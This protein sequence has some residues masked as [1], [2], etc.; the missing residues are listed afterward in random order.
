[1]IEHEN[2]KAGIKTIFLKKVMT[3]TNSR[4]TV[5]IMASPFSWGGGSELIRLIV[6]SLS[7]E[8]NDSTKIIVFFGRNKFD[9][10]LNTLNFIKNIFHKGKKISSSLTESEMIDF[11]KDIPGIH[12][13]HYTNSPNYK[14]LLNKLQLNKVDALIPVPTVL[15]DSFS[16]PWI[17]YIPDLQHKHL[18]HFFT[19]EEITTRDNLYSQMLLKAKTVIVNSIQVK[20]DLYKYY[21]VKSKIFSL[22]FAP[23]CEAKWL[24]NKNDSQIIKKYSLPNKFFMI[25]NQFWVHKSYET[26]FESMTNSNFQKQNIHLVCTGNLSDYRFP[27]YILKLK[28]QISENNLTDRIHLLGHIPKDDQIAIMKRSIAVIQPTLFEGGPGGGSVYNAIAVGTPVIVSDIPINHELSGDNILFFKTQSSND[29]TEK[30]LMVLKKKISRP[31]QEKLLQQKTEK[32]SNLC[33]SLLKIL[34]S[35]INRSNKNEN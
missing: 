30:M 2:L 10:V 11:L 21:D 19:D 17:G 9:F 15:P 12:F 20:E 33:A 16:I 1:M 27:E 23:I 22:P 7:I 31:S 29:L 13:D 14:N 18:S 28:K 5:A 3:K 25:S 8:A 6:S 26:A 4:Q 32:L 34:D 24:T 35:S